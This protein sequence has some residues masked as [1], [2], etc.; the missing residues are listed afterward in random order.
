MPGSTMTRTSLLRLLGCGLFWIDAQ[1]QLSISGIE[2]DG[3]AQSIPK[4]G[5]NQAVTASAAARHYKFHFT[6][7]LHESAPANRLRYKLQGYDTQWKEL[8]STMRGYMQFLDANASSIGMQDFYLAGETPG[9]RGR[10]EISDFVARRE[11]ATVP[12][13]AAFVQI[14]LLS[15]GPE[16]TVGLAGF[17]AICLRE[18]QPHGEPKVYELSL[19][20]G[21]DL[22][23]PHGKPANWDRQGSRVSIAELRT[24]AQPKP[25]PILVFNDN[26]PAQYGMW[27]LERSKAIPVHPGARLTLE[28][29][30]AHSIG[31]GGSGVV[32][33]P[34]L[35]AGNYVLR[36]AAF[37]ANGE[38]KGLEM[39][40]P[41][42]ISAPLHQRPIFWLL[43]AAIGSGG[44]AWLSRIEVQRRMQRRMAEVERERAM[45]RERERIAR[46]LHDHVGAG[47]TEIAMQSDWVDSDLEQ[48]PN[49][50]TRQRVRSI[51]QSATDL[52]R[53]LDEM[54]WAVNPANDTLK[55]FVSYLMQCT[56]QFLQPAGVRVRFD[57]P[58]KLPELSLE[59]KVRHALFL[60]V[61]EALN[62]AVKHAGA[63]LVTLEVR[64]AQQLCIFL[65]D[66]G[67]GFDCC[68]AS[69]EGTHD[70]LL[71]MRKRME[72]IGGEFHVTS[73][74]GKGTRI[75]ITAPFANH[76]SKPIAARK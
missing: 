63:T 60:V 65:E 31:K 26:D 10:P 34:Q 41:I 8:P 2:V 69:P 71:N 22:T 43:L 66:D 12:E 61:R 59:G 40:L 6:H 32:S 51:R 28:W 24:R 52:A 54:V 46:D 55:R 38:P 4:A 45:E 58:P 13:G 47:L 62:N 74:P 18:E 76:D 29:Q 50:Q 7:A 23:Q 37:E 53:S 35:K 67:S 15:H 49:A 27:V 11:N 16:S 48:G 56:A 33:Y 3:V 21:I 70:G 9:W 42:L 14:V 1:A 17:D 25:H 30:T 19:A 20:E 5:S 75:K 73:Q 64:C 44:A 36:I 39:L 68:Q 57:V 72:E